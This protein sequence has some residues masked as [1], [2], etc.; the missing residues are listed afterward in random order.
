M[1]TMDVFKGE[2]N[3]SLKE[4]FENTNSGSRLSE[5]IQDLKVE[6]YKENPN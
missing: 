3:K 2:A 1:N 5:T 4:I 6:I